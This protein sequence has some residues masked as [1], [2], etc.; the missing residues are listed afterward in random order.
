MLKGIAMEKIGLIA[1]PKRE[2]A[3]EAIQELVRWLEQRGKKV[4][5]DDQ[6]AKL[7]GREALGRPAEEIPDLSNMVIALGG[8]GTVLRV[9]RLMEK[10]DI[11]I[12]AV[13]IGGLGF[14][15]VITLPELYPALENVLNHKYQSALHM[16]LQASV[17]RGGEEVGKF[18]ALNDVVITKGA[19]SRLIDLEISIGQEY[20]TTYAADGLIISTPTGSTAHSLSAGG[21]IVHSTM[22]ALILTPICPHTLTNRPLI[23][24]ERETIYVAIKSAYPETT[25]TMDGQVGFPLNSGDVVEVERAPFKVRLIRSAK[26]GYYGILR[27]KLN[28]GG[29]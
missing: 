9:A 7:C 17:M 1:N 12:L 11:P 28:W 3:V 14:L 15:T 29:R 20:V 4:F 8:D 10:S 26:K 5:V 24:S 16:M 2:G 18:T 6:S 27:E 13:N 21:P 25:L 23:V 19:V 22:D